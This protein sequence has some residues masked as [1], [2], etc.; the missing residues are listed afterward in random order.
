MTTLVLALM[1]QYVVATKA[2]LVNDV[3]GLTN[4]KPMQM[5]EANVPV[6]TGPSGFAE[7]LLT[8]GAYL[9]L[10]SNAGVGLDSVD[11]TNVAFHVNVGQAMIEGVEI[12]SEAPI[13][14]TPGQTPVNLREPGIFRSRDGVATVVEGKFETATD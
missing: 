11:L 14:V 12:T 1:M 8:P 9:R 3:K 4:I 6:R 5:V 2:G 10:G 7:L 13:R